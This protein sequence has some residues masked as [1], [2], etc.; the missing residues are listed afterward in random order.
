ME[1]D[2]R[3]TYGWGNMR[4]GNGTKGEGREKRKEGE[5]NVMRSKI[6]LHVHSFRERKM[7][8]NDEKRG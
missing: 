4:V 2:S 5:A 1:G 7:G 8:H 3:D 6:L